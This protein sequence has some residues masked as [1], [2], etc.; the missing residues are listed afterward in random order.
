MKL[1][2]KNLFLSFF[3]FFFIKLLNSLNEMIDVT[4]N[5]YNHKKL[6]KNKHKNNIPDKIKDVKILFKKFKFIKHF[7]NF[8]LLFCIF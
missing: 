2:N 5:K 1:Y 8:F 3:N 4:T 6:F 7:Q